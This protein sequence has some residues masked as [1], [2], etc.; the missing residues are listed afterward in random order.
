MTP[1]TAINLTDVSKAYP[2]YVSR[3]DR[4]ASLFFGHR[5]RE[6]QMF[7]AVSGVNL[8]IRKGET[9]GILGVNG[10]G[11]STLLQMIAGTLTPTSGAL[12]VD[13]KVSALLELGSGFNPVWSGRENAAFQCRINGVE[14]AQIPERL[15]EIEAFADVGG[16]FDQPMRTY[17]SGMYM[18]VAFASAITVDPDILIVD[19]A[20]AVG[21]ARFQNKCFSRFFDLQKAGKTIL[22]VTH[23]AEL[24]ARVCTRG[25]LLDAGAVKF[26]GSPNEAVNHYLAAL[27]GGEVGSWKEPGLPSARGAEEKTGPDGVSA[28]PVK[29]AF[30]TD[31]KGDRLAQRWFYNKNE[32]RY[33]NGR[34]KILDADI[35]VNGKP[36]AGMLVSKSRMSII[37]RAHAFEDLED[38]AFGVV[39]KTT[40][41][42]RI[43][44]TST[45]MKKAALF[46]LKAFKYHE[47]SIDIDLPLFSGDYFLDV[48]CAVFRN[49]DYIICDSRQS[50]VHVYVSSSEKFNG[51]VDLNSEFSQRI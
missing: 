48:S 28:A 41:N 9:V 20:L 37:L 36:H 39:L 31:D 12:E 22:F 46:N 15:K 42:V 33:G 6:R 44:G 49:G 2:L 13:G 38:V 1:G 18:R 24:V 25:V 47:F 5:W 30:A 27:Y 45:Q 29:P 8:S 50:A 14:E 51:L 26:D 17:S 43:Y 35:H 23:S 3:K 7:S 34:A 32:N 21:D 11:K 4:L 10:A 16:F 40:D 19:E